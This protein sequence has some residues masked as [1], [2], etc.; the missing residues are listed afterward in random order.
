[1]RKVTTINLNGRA[2]QLE[3]DGYEKLQAYLRQAAAALAQNPDKA[4]VLTDIEQAIADKCDRLLIGNKNVV[5]SEQMIDILEQMGKVE[6]ADSADDKQSSQRKGSETRQNK[7]LFTIKEGA[8]ILGVCKGIGAYLGVDPTL[9]R[10]AFVVLAFLTQGFAVV[11]Y[12]ALGLLLPT[13]KTEADLAEAYNQPMTAQDIA[14]RAK[15][16][17]TDP[18]TVERVGQVF[19]QIMRVIFQI[20]Q[21]VAAT[22]FGLVTAAWLITMWS[23]AFGNLSL[24]DNLQMLNGWRAS[25]FIS[26]AYAIAALPLL[27]LTRIMGRLADTKTD[28]T[29][30]TKLA[31]RGEGV[32][33]TLWG[34]SAVGLIIF[35]TTYAG[36]V[37][38][39]VDTH[40]GYM[41]VGNHH[42]CA[43][44]NRCD[45]GR[46]FHR[47]MRE[48]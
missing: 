34:L 44:A 17:A 28:D 32:L 1:M 8:M 43:D 3:E 30:E 23:M 24:H 11:L 9:V 7:R 26:F 13:A 16:K 14:D 15:E 46:N 2:F 18:E 4:E 20:I 27:A 47:R 48:D 33:S 42:I 38:R 22:A 36:D 25:L 19:T 40:Q 39:Y 45:P 21:I 12:L 37:R 6:T 10:I 35:I 5:T 41:D 29:K 31:G